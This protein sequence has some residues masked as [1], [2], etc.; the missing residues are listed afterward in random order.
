MPIENYLIQGEEILAKAGIFY[1]TNKR[2]IRY[3]KHLLN[4][5]FDDIPYAHLSSIGVARNSRRGLIWTSITIISLVLTSLGTLAILAPILKSISGLIGGGTQLG[6]NLGPL[7]P[8]HLVGLALGVLLLVLAI[9]LPNSYIQFR[10][11]GS[12]KEAEAR[13]RL[14][15]AKREAKQNLL[16]TIRQQS[17][18][19]TKSEIASV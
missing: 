5:E 12:N 7:I 9:S 18:G 15:R 14:I 3:Q 2:L 6:F 17:L 19:A 16:R 4:E 1:A 13:F 11:P 8:I 10:A